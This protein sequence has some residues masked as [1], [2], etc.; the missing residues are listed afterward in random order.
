MATWGIGAAANGAKY[1]RSL[2]PKWISEKLTAA[3]RVGAGIGLVHVDYSRVHVLRPEV[4]GT[5]HD[6]GQAGPVQA[7]RQHL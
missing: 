5:R 1:L 3:R 6:G 2:D 7:V 4:P